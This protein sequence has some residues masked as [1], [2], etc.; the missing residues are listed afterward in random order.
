MY[1]FIQCRHE[2]WQNLGVNGNANVF[3]GTTFNANVNANVSLRR[4][5]NG[6]ANVNYFS[7][8]LSMPISMAM[9]DAL[10]QCQ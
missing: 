5:F 9:S 10:P 7:S 1:T 3:G 6:N 8:A 4:L 2:Q